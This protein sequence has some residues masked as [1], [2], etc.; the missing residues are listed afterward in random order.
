[1][2]PSKNT[3]IVA[4]LATCAMFPIAHSADAAENGVINY[5]TGSPGIFISALPP[6]PGLFAVSQTSYSYADGLYGPNGKKLAVPFEMSA[7][8]EVVRILA[9]YDFTLFGANVYSQLI[10]PMVHLNTNVFGMESSGSGFAN[11]TVSPIIMN[12]R[13]DKYQ[14]FTLGLDI[15]SPISSYDATNGLVGGN[16]TTF[17]PTIA[18]RYNDPKGFEFGISPRILFNTEN[19]DTSYS[20]GTTVVVDFMA[21]W[22]FG[23]WRVGVA[24]GYSKQIAGDKQYGVN[25]GNELSEFKA[26]PSLTYDAGPVIVN[27][28]WQPSWYVENGANSSTVWLNVAFPIYAGA[29]C[30]WCCGALS[31]K[32]VDAALRQ[33][34]MSP[35]RRSRGECMAG[36]RPIAHTCAIACRA[37]SSDRG[38]INGRCRIS[39]IIDVQLTSAR[40]LRSQIGKA[41]HSTY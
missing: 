33:P 29:T 15:A 17:Q 12:W 37:K 4:A 11:I 24:G 7:Y 13:L 20:S 6:I 2:I 38:R 10:V 35:E 36:R 28:N 27:F 3:H 16:Y 31:R 18:Y 5:T 1:M 19:T 26:G 30:A 41:S 9:S 25:I 22:H 8:A 14:T 32:N 39:A 34:P 40:A 21:N 23:A